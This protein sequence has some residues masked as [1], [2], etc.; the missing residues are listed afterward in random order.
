M[1]DKAKGLLGLMFHSDE[2]VCLSN[3]KFATHSIRLERA[4]DETVTLVSPNPKMPVQLVR[5]DD[6][7]FAALNPIKGFRNDKNCYKLRNF[8]L[9]ID[10]YDR[11]LQVG[12][13]KK[14]GIPYS[15][16][17]WSGS[18]SVHLLVSLDADLSL[19][20]YSEIY[21]WMLNIGGL[22]DQ[23][24]G[25]PSRNIRL[26]GAIRPE[27]GK[28]QELIELQ[29]K[30]T[31]KDLF[32]WLNRYEHLRPKQKEKKKIVAGSEDFS[33]L[34]GWARTML[35][36]GVVFKNKGRNQTWFGLAYDMALAGF[37][38][39]KT[40]QELSARFTE[41]HDFKEKEFLITISSAFKKVHER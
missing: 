35:T 17:I 7:V 28:E 21:R 31:V 29:G 9:E 40:I 12:Y 27:T 8:L 5:S 15:A 10:N 39:E 41:E 13:I 14:L 4:F 34:S 1:N 24:L 36:K 11:D 20:R 26:P 38:E 32:A 2:D 18:K 6:L 22:F 16:M 23:Q 30:V 3:L 19:Q 25:N 37:S 33:R